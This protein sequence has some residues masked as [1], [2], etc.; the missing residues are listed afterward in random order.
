MPKKKVSPNS[1]PKGGEG[2]KMERDHAFV[3]VFFN[4]SLKGDAVNPLVN[5]VLPHNTLRIG[6]GDSREWM[7]K[8]LLP[9]KKCAQ[10]T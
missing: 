3:W 9:E 8:D 4:P 1:A 6:F 5:T 10:Q 7:G 2:V